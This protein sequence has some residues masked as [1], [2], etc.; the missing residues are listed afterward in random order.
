MIQTW[1]LFD[2]HEESIFDAAIKNFE[3]SGFFVE[4][5][6]LVLHI[7]TSNPY[8]HLVCADYY[9]AISDGAKRFENDIRYDEYMRGE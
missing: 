9:L 1:V 3:R 5:T 7:S 8:D 6:D 2:H 4:A